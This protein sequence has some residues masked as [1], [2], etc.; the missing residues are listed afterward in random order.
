M[1]IAAQIELEQKLA[2][3]AGDDR[4]EAANTVLKLYRQDRPKTEPYKSKLPTL[5]RIIDGLNPGQL[6]SISGPTGHGKTTLAQTVT[7]GLAEQLAF[8]LW[9]SYEVNT[10]DF[11]DNF[12]GDYHEHIFMPLKLLDNTIE[13]LEARI[14][15]AKLKHDIRAVFIDHLHY[16]ISMSPKQNASFAI[17][18]TV[19]ALKQLALK[20]KIVMFLLS[21]MMKT[22][23][24]QEPCLG[25]IRDSSFVEQESDVVLYVWRLQSD[26]SLT[27]LKIAKNRRRGIIDDRIALTFV[28]GRYH[29]K[30]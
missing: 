18:E 8:S 26:K 7:R 19:R 27:V 6:F 30:V 21:H 10:E 1:N 29:E 2:S 13:W 24:D 20:H 11:L 16:L 15:E 12:P 23:S 9:F 14:I 22:K 17:G 5:D 3:Y 4:V 28:D 25:D